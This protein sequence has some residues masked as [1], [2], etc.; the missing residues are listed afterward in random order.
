MKR[1]TLFYML[2]SLVYIVQA[3][4]DVELLGQLSYSQ[5]LSDVW[6][7]V[8]EEGNE[9]AL[10]GVYNGFS[11]VDVTD[12]T[13]P[14][15]V[16]FESGPQSIWR[17]IKTWGDYAYVSNESYDGVLIV[18]LSPLP[19]GPI[20]TSTNFTGSNYDFDSAHNLYIDEFGKL[21]IF[22]ADNGSGGAIICDVASSPMNPQELGRFNN[23]YLHDGMARGDTL[24]GAGIYQG[25]L[26]AIDV[27][28]PGS[29]TIMGTV[30]TPGQFAHNCW[31]SDDGTHVFTTDEIS[32]GY[33]GAYNVEDLGNM[34]ETDR[35]QSS[36]GANVIPHNVHV[37]NNFLITSYYTDGLV[38]HDAI[39]PENIIEV[40]SY[41]TSPNYSGN[42]FNGAWG[43]YP[44]LPS[45]NIL[46]SDIEEGLYI[47][48]FNFYRAA[49]V[50]GTVM[51]SISGDPIFAV[52]V[53]VLDTGLSTQTLF[54]GSF[55][56]AATISGTYDIQFS[57]TFYKTK[58]I[59]GVEF[60]QGEV[61]D[62]E[63]ELASALSVSVGEQELANRINVFP[64][65]AK[66]VFNLNYN[67]ISSAD[68]NVKVTVYSVLGNKVDEF[69]LDDFSGSVS[70]GK[71]YQPGVYLLHI[72]NGISKG[73]RRLVK[74]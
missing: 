59:E 45:G 15:E 72:N 40:G 57:K 32:D 10:V 26:A 28:D 60:V 61:Q 47:L 29:P 12:P 4:D 73:M 21:Y 46:V 49:F 37:R 3:Q 56:I 48:S 30:S 18:D 58:I 66:T 51:D 74:E 52:N 68:G 24:W 8:D 31:V 44:F 63:V 14:E 42:G 7:Y 36:P 69:I 67:D 22:G 55:E 70:F 64:N 41:D 11:V 54:D 23:Y 20:T 19:D 33:I 6:G 43:A 25:V 39:N 71:Q 27:S 35:I 9:Y 62:L 53:D 5:E 2:L 38:I 50:Q 17:D 1:I 13:N 65:P 16:Y 34:F